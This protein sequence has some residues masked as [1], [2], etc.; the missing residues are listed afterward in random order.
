MLYLFFRITSL[1][2]A[3]TKKPL[4]DLRVAAFLFHGSIGFL[5]GGLE[6]SS[7]QG[8]IN[9]S[10]MKT[11]AESSDFRV[12]QSFKPYLPH[13]RAAFAFSDISMPSLHLPALRSACQELPLVEYQTD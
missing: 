4:P 3:K 12:E 1:S 7:V 2:T 9:F 13:Y 10:I 11:G 6:T 5:L 8:N